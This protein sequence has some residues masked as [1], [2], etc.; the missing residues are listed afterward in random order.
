[1]DVWPKQTNTVAKSHLWFPCRTL[2]SWLSGQDRPEV[3]GYTKRPSVTQSGADLTQVGP[4]QH[5]D[6]GSHSVNLKSKSNK[7]RPWSPTSAL[8]LTIRS[9]HRPKT[10][11]THS[12]QTGGHGR[13]ASGC[14]RTHVNS[15]A[16]TNTHAARQIT[17]KI[18][19]TGQKDS[20][21]ERQVQTSY[22]PHR[23]TF[24]TACDNMDMCVS[25]RVCVCWGPCVN[26]LNMSWVC[27]WGDLC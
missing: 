5:S 13:G 11:E 22:V 7:H 14:W 2:F 3:G 10:A 27:V 12:A 16:H 19:Q 18:K 21:N 25:A 20:T 17:P 24:I 15:T 1:M 9:L 26:A 23:R 4:G 6:P 8:S